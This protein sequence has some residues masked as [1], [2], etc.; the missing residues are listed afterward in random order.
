M[1]LTHEGKMTIPNSAFIFNLGRL[2]QGVVSERWDEVEYVSK[3][4]SEITPAHLIKTY[5]REL[6]KLNVAIEKKDAKE[7]DKVLQVIL[8]W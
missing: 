2:W 5:L 8:K 3:F 4:I 6:K 7:I 1:S